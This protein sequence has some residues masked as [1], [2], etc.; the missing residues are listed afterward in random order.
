M[1]KVASEA[2]KAALTKVNYELNDLKTGD[3]FFPPDADSA[4]ALKVVPVHDNVHDKIQGDRH[5]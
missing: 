4:R 5:P 1:K 3:P 2:L